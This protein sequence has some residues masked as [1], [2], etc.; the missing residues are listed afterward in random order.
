M[1]DMQ[2]IQ[3][4]IAQTQAFVKERFDPIRQE[5]GLVREEQERLTAQV[6]G[7][8]DQLETQRRAALLTRT[9]NDRPRVRGGR[10]D[11]C[12]L[13]D[14]A[15]LRSL[16]MAQLA[17]PQ[18]YDPRML[19]EWEE[20]VT[21]AMD[22]TT[23][24]AGEELVSTEAA[25]QLWADVNLEAAVASLFETVPMP[26]NP[27]DIPL[28]L[29]DV[30]WYPGTPNTATSATALTTAKQ[31]LTAYEL[32]GMVPWAY[33]LEEDAVVA[34]MAE[35][36]AT[37]LRNAAQVLD[38][39]LLN[40]DTTTTNNINHDG[41]SLS[42]STDGKAQYLIG[43]DGLLHLPLEDHSAQ[44]NSLGGAPEAGMF[45]EL[46]RMVG[47]YGVRPSEQ[48]F[49]TDV[50]T[51]IASQ[52]IEEF[53]T[54]DKLGPNATLL[55]GQLGSVEGIPVI[56]SE[57]M[58]LANADGT[59]NASGTG[60]DKGRLLLVNRTQWRKGFKRELLIETERDVQ[61]RQNV[62]VVSMRLAFSERTGDRANATHTALHYN[63]TV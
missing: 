63:I 19:R 45:N 5:I 2:D 54:L 42:T 58:A 14:L 28:Q 53:Q 37:L 24:G 43:F 48:A 56:V 49:V 57:Q 1:T 23:A 50:A 27:F 44:G 52:A 18:D 17:R 25:R 39:M 61:K 10:L 13:V 6:R 38:D 29:G 32:V 40:A 31:T 34:M 16:L 33:E 21:R 62:M 51:F 47:R 46:R 26:T 11:G 55:T 8:M 30:H 41:S 59:V 4:E 20:S 9:A 35:V 12:D 7:V 36:R 22:S 15:I 3:K 60:N